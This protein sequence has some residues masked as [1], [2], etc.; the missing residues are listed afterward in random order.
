MRRLLRDESGMTLVELM[1]ASVVLVLVMA[2]LSNMFVSGLR[3]G[4]NG[5][6]R[7]ASQEAVRTAFDRLEYETRCAETATLVS[8]GAGV[9]LSLPGWCPNAT[10]DVAWCV[11][12]G[13]LVRIAGGTDCTG[14]GQTLVTDVS[15]ATPFS[16]LTPTGDLPRLEVSLTASTDGLAADATS[17]VDDIAMRNAAVTSGETA[18]CT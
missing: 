16:C 4:T 8:S 10:G 18:A 5:N 3:A 12:S 14:S 1:I 9:A 6:A 2:G 15:S 7:L 13:S 11:Q 17:A